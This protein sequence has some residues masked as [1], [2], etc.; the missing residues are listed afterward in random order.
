MMRVWAS[1][2][3]KFTSELKQ[4]ACLFQLVRKIYLYLQFYAFNPVQVT[5]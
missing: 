2:G 3:F 1:C 5:I 4:G